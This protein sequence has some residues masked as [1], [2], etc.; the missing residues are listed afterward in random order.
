[1]NE[2][3]HKRIDAFEIIRSFKRDRVLDVLKEYM[4]KTVLFPEH[5]KMTPKTYICRKLKKTLENVQS[6]R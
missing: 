5:M 3:S 6:R 1:M 2:I 4:I